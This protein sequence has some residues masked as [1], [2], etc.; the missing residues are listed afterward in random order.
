MESFDKWLVICQI[1]PA[2]LFL[3]LWS[4]QLIHQSFCLSKFCVSPLVK[5]LPRQTLHYMVHTVTKHLSDNKCILNNYVDV[6][7]TDQEAVQWFRSGAKELNLL[8]SVHIF[9]GPSIVAFIA[10]D[11]ILSM[12]YAYTH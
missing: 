5:I 10:S 4:L 7:T 12:L 11:Q 2:N 8:F 6:Y 9:P 1:S 3:F